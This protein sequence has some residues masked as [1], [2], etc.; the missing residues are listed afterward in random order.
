MPSFNSSTPAGDPS[1]SVQSSWKAPTPAPPL[2]S[3]SKY[4]ATSFWCY[5]DP[6]FSIT[7]N[8]GGNNTS[9][10]PMFST[11]MIC[12]QVAALFDASFAV[13][14]LVITSPSHPLFDT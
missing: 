7:T 14:V 10:N 6:Q 1:A 5:P 12:L 9:S 8:D 13:H 2:E 3:T 11:V 4:A